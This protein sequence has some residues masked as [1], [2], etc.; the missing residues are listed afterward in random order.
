MPGSCRE[1]NQ[2]L[3][4]LPHGRCGMHKKAWQPSPKAGEAEEGAQQVQGEG[5]TGE[6]REAT[7]QPALLVPL[8]MGCMGPC[9][10]GGIPWHR[11]NFT[12]RG[13]QVAERAAT[14]KEPCR[15]MRGARAERHLIFGMSVFCDG[16]SI[17]PAYRGATFH[18]SLAGPE[19]CARKGCIGGLPESF[20]LSLFRASP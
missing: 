16:T 20:V 4:N 9:R 3:V 14:V 15:E 11:K 12:R 19:Q 13:E 2:E 7:W 5:V 17:D 8:R 1:S 6:S 18:H 10:L